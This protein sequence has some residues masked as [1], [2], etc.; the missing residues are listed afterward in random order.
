MDDEMVYYY[1]S[2]SILIINNQ[3]KITRLYTPFSVLC[4]EAVDD[5]KFGCTFLV[6]EI[7]PDEDEMLLYKIYGNLYPYNYFSIIQH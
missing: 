3:S 4:I 6:D 2:Y 1:D 7:F 5:L